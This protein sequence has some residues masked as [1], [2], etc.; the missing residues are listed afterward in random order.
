MKR[1]TALTILVCLAMATS[2]HAAQYPLYAG[3]NIEIGFV[4]VGHD[5]DSLQVIYQIT[6]EAWILV[7]TKLAVATR[8]NGI[9][10]QVTQSPDSSH[11]PSPM[12]VA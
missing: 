9:P 8:L 1:L 3:Q 7:D 5:D 4:N 10:S 2:V 6:D 12:G 11:I